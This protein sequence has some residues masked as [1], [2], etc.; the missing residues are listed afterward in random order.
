[1]LVDQ[2]TERGQLVA[3]IPPERLVTTQKSFKVPD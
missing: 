1:M 3:L 2:E